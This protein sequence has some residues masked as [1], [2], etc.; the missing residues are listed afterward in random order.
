MQHSLSPTTANKV[1]WWETTCFGIVFRAGPRGFPLGT[2][3][4]SWDARSV[5][6]RGEL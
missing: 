6:I 1:R 2:H 3:R 5:Q 4:R